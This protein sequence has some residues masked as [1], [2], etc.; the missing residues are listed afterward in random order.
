MSARGLAALVVGLGGG[1]LKGKDR[2][3]REDIEDEDRAYLM[4]QRARQKA[5]N[6]RTDQLRTDMG[7]A[8]MPT[9][10]EAAPVA[11]PIGS[12][13]EPRAPEDVGIRAAGQTF[14]DRA[15]A[16][17]A[18]ADYN[19]PQATAARQAQVAAAAGD[20]HLAQ[21]LRTG[22]M[23][24]QVAKLQLSA[25]ERAELKAK[26]AEQI[27]PLADFG[28][29]G[30]FMSASAADGQG[31]KL[32][33]QFVPAADG[34]TVALNMVNPD[35]SLKP[36]ARTFDNDG[37]G[38]ALA[39][40]QLNGMP[41]EK[42]LEH[43]HR[44]A[45]EARAAAAQQSTEKY[46]AGMLK[47]AQDKTASQIENA[48]LRAQLA[49]AAGASGQ[50]GMTLA[51]L[52]DG[53]KGIA[54]TLNADWKG[55]IDSTTDPVALKAIKVARENEIATVQRLYTG[56]MSAGFGLT[57]EQAIVA[58]RSGTVG[59]Q[60]FKDKGGNTVSVEGVQYGGRFIPLADNP[61]AAGA[62]AAAPKPG[63]AAA[64]A[65]PAAQGAAAPAEK[66]VKQAPVVDFNPGSGPKRRMSE[67]AS[68]LPKLEAAVAAATEKVRA[69]ASGGPMAVAAAR[70]EL[71][72]AKTALAEM[73][74][75]AGN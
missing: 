59:T 28:Q 24:E 60:S 69:A 35:G 27:N 70:N 30:E 68:K 45:V 13:D 71:S 33:M 4:E 37:K 42:M 47:N 16:D 39:K 15:A 38:L 8:S 7:N 36:T 51:D 62:P 49:K 17:K 20:P 32:K 2:Q 58:F 67:A 21:Q 11:M 43:F 5:E 50:G 29:L 48:G 73:S 14:T 26:F 3:R 57:P 12:R 52:K 66:R 25:G 1:Y 10:V 40:A 6:A 61:G 34:K 72:N 19:T 55:Q 9:T 54:S 53:H 56:A 75:R 18:A 41:P 46:Q 64:P 74:T 31:G 22:S 23:Q 65:A 63:P 44:E